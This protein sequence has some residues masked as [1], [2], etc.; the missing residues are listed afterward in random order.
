[1]GRSISREEAWRDN[2]N[3]AP[4][5]VGSVGENCARQSERM[6]RDVKGVIEHE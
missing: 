1:M 3:M 2:L 6:K 4:F 5:Y